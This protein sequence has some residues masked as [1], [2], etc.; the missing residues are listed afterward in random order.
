MER[1]GFLFYKSFYDVVKELPKRDQNR[2]LIAIIELGLTDTIDE[3]LPIRMKAALIQ[4]RAS[5][6]AA[7]KKRDQARE[8]G[9]KGGA[10]VGNQNASKKKDKNNQSVDLKQPKE[11]ENRKGNAK[12]NTFTIRKGYNTSSGMAILE[13]GQPSDDSDW[14]SREEMVNNGS[15]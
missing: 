4:I 2:M 12:A 3:T 11:K 9:K 1:D 5:I 7:Q 6:N 8:N 13:G 10:P 15:V 14:M